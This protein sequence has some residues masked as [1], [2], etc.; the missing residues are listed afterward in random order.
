MS[1]REE[2]LENDR[3]YYISKLRQAIILLEKIQRYN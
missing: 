2:M 3:K 1:N